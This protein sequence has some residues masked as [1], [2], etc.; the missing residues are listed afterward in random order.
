MKHPVHKIGFAVCSAALGIGAVVLWA[1]ACSGGE[2]TTPNC[3]PL[4]RYNIDAAYADDGAVLNTPFAQQVAAARQAAE[5][6]G[7]ATP[8]GHALGNVTK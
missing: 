8:I 2:A 7:C 3:P 1:V 5:A 4:M 6:A